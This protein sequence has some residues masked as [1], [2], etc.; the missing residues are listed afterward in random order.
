[1]E[2]LKTGDGV[3]WFVQV[4]PGAKAVLVNSA[5]L[6]TL[7]TLDD[8]RIDVV[9]IATGET[10][11]VENGGYDP[12]YLP[13]FGKSGHLVFL[14]QGILFAVRFDPQ[15]L[16]VEGTPT[17]VLSDL[18]NASILDGGG[19][20]SVA[21]NGTFVYLP[22]QSG[23]RAYPISWLNAAGQTTPLVLQPGV[24]GAPRISPDGSRLAYTATGTK[25]A[26]VW[27]YDF[28]RDAPTQLTFTGPGLR[29]LAWAPDSKHLVFGDGESLW[30]IR[31][32][33]SGMPQKL[34]EKTANPRPFSFSPDG[35]LV[36]SPF[37]AQGLP[38]IW[39]LPID[40]RDTERPKAGKP[41]PFLTDAFVE[42]DAA[43]SP[44]GK[45]IA[46]ASNEFVA[47]NDI[48][49]RSFPGK[50]GKW[51]VST[52]GGKYPAWSPQTR[53]LF[54]LGS[55]D[56]IMVASYT[57]TGDSFA[58]AAPRPWSPTQVF[59]D[60]VRQSFD[61]AP[62]GKRVVMFPRPTETKNEGSLHVT[63]LLNFFDEVRRRVP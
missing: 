55:D 1:L 20:L 49:V 16:S 14:R 26:D 37:G 57:I 28:Q 33:G 17:A 63:F 44:D 34:L 40:L 3:R 30:W 50:G 43:F 5:N 23:H 54:F 6:T 52:G 31:A 9:D 62:D 53:E 61:V 10:K 42:V 15:R 59:R 29:E 39:T 32:D 41:E 11:T 25:G 45:F 48:F 8:L 22:R 13:T 7:T 46:Y 19:Q 12:R 21:N 24:Y 51:R 38:D 36:Y 4:L 35:R 60:G 2:R 58:A 47:N 18:G 27:V 56:R